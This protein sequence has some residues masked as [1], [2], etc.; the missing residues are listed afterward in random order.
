MKKLLIPGG[1]I[2]LLSGFLT[3]AALL[4]PAVLAAQEPALT[5][6]EAVKMALR[7]NERAISAGEELTAA[8]ARVAQARAAFLPSFIASTTYTRRPFE[9]TRQIGNT[10]MVIQSFN[11]LSG[12]GT[13]N[14]T[15]F[16]AANI[17]TFN[18][19][20]A[21]RTAQEFA[22]A[23]SRRQLSFEV[24]QA[25]LTALSTMQVLEASKHRYNYAR[26]NL[27]A[28]KARYDAGLVSVNDVTRVELELASAE[29]SVIQ[30]QGQTETTILQF[31][32]LL[33][34]PD[35][36]KK[37]LIAPE[38]LIAADSSRFDDIES[39]I[40]EAQIRRLDLNALRWEAK[41]QQALILQ[42][43]LAWFPSLSFATRVTYTNEAGLTGR[44]WNW[45]LGLTLSWSIFDGLFRNAQYRE[46]NAL[47][48]IADLDVQAALRG[49]EVDVRQARVS[50]ASQKAALKQAEVALD[51]AKK[52]AHETSELYRQGLATALEVADATVSLF[53]AEVAQVRQR[54]NLGISF[55]NLEAALGLDPFGKEPVR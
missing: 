23:E 44:N 11:A 29:M 45:N 46:L 51:V 20:K 52:N 7:M 53:E 15:L 4:L 22:S 33:N 41:A 16:N 14:L 48:K 40:G 2:R 47:A 50:L 3:L 28:A 18:Y 5:L 38:F 43:T 24:G 54:F 26:Q 30:G 13:L 1:T 55:L 12:T 31:G 34:D 10:S 21:G 36:A 42:S 9:V 37:T 35:V 8:Q 39:M 49:V 6:E 17:P 32:N 25:F 19:Y 27:E